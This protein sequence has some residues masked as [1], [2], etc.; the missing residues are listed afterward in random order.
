METPTPPG[1]A[2]PIELSVI[3]PCL[4]EELNI[5]ELTERLLRTFEVGGFSGE[6]IFVDDGSTDGTATVIRT[7]EAAHP[8][9]DEGSSPKPPGQ[10]L[11]VFHPKNLG[12]AEAWKS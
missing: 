7:L 8:V 5:P 4:N 1:A 11:G 10:V 9:H 3:V 6:I 12:M 2:E